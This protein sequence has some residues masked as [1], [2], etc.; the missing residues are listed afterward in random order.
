MVHTVPVE[1]IATVTVLIHCQYHVISVTTDY[2]LVPS[3]LYL[4][5]MNTNTYAITEH[6]FRTFV[7]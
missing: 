6:T 4:H 7:L 3:S 2:L 1:L 5:L